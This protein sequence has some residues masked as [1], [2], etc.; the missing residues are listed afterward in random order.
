[1][2]PLGAQKK[3]MDV[4]SAMGVDVVVAVSHEVSAADTGMVKYI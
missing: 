4:A 2:D 3:V 1:M